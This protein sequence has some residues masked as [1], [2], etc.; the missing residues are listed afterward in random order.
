MA[1]G[2]CQLTIEEDSEPPHDGGCYC[3]VG[4]TRGGRGKGVYYGNAEWEGNVGREIDNIGLQAPL[5]TRVL[6]QYSRY[7]IPVNIQSQCPS[8]PPGEFYPDM[9]QCRRKQ[10][11]C[12]MHS[13]PVAHCPLTSLHS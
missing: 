9:R 10:L 11:S 12:R 5:N 2:E 1:V 6:I 4:R 3:W 8:C 7:L 13:T